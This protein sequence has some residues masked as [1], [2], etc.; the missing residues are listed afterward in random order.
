MYQSIN[1]NTVQ[2][3][4]PFWSTTLGIQFAFRCN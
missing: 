1:N 4:Y 2:I 3:P